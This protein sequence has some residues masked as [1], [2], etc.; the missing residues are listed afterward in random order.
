MEVSL[1]PQYERLYAFVLL[2]GPD[3]ASLGAQALREM[4]NIAV[5]GSKDK[6]Y[7][8]FAQ[9]RDVRQ[10]EFG[11]NHTNLYIKSLLQSV[12]SEKVSEAFKK[13][14]KSF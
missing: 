14:G 7:V 5:E 13:Y 9:K 3:M 12:T 4:N 2:E 10:K 11:K 8:N 1:S 6:L